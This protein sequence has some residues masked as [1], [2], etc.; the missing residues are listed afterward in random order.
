MSDKHQDEYDANMIALLELFW[1]KAFMAPG[2]EGNVNRILDGLDLRNK[3]VLEIGSGLGGGALVMARD[4]G[5]EVVGFEVEAPLV[6]RAREYA[7]NEGLQDKVEFRVV[8][9]GPLQIADCS[10]DVVYSSG[11]FIHIEDKSKFFR[12]I[13]RVLKPGGVLAAYDWLK[14]PGPLS[15]AMHDW[16]RLEELTFYLDTLENY[17]SMFEGAGFEHVTTTDASTWYA[18]EARRE[19]E[20]MKG[21][22]FDQVTALIGQKKRDH[23]IK[24]WAAMVRVLESGELRSGYIRAQ[25]PSLE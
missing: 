18:R 13:L 9:P 12:D 8:D 25:R 11:V 1:G 6:D 14:G 23:F 10:V 15:E 22:L 19:Y 17:A 4:Y 3:K 20:L 5:A 7:A 2:G 24:D 21:P 16:I